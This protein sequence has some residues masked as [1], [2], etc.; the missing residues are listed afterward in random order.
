MGAVASAPTPDS[1]LESE[2]QLQPIPLPLVLESQR[3][4]FSPI[5]NGKKYPVLDLNQCNDPSLH[6]TAFLKESKGWD[7]LVQYLFLF[8]WSH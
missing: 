3:K 5:L 2:P 1:I 8:L 7:L 4:G 6:V